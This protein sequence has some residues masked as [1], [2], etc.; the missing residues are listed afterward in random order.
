MATEDERMT[1]AMVERGRKEA[2]VKKSQF[3]VDAEA[4]AALL[5]TYLTRLANKK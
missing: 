1:T 5:E 3:D 2:G 4:A